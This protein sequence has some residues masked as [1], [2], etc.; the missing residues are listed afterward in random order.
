MD[1]VNII[2]LVDKNAKTRFTK[3]YQNKIIN[4]IRY[5]FEPKHQ[6]LFLSNFY[7]SVN[8]DPKKDFVIDFDRLWKWLG[9]NR[10]EIPRRLLEKH[11]TNEIDY[12]I[13][14]EGTKDKITLNVNTYK[15]FSMKAGTKKS[16]E[17]ID[18]YILLQDI[19]IEVMN[20]QSDE[21]RNQLQK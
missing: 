12:I 16:D 14:K 4:R 9:F 17:I 2:Q 18:C 11:F 8:F 15:K 5:R 13:E 20:E 3:E 21:L 19:L 1:T 7:L 6:Q 10:K